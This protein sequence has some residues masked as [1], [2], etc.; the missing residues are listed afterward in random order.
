MPVIPLISSR[1]FRHRHCRHAPLSVRSA[2]FL[3]ASADSPCCRS[4]APWQKTRC[5][6][7]LPE[8]SLP[9]FRLSLA[10]VTLGFIRAASGSPHVFLR[11]PVVKVMPL[12]TELSGI[13][14]SYLSRCRSCPKD[15]IATATEVIARIGC[16]STNL[17]ISS[18][19]LLQKGDEVG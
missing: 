3:L 12:A 2:G 17:S 8:S 15:L 6:S 4:R 11:S 9:L 10:S 5:L 13:V 14:Y 1:R 18:L 7:L 16:Q 19:I